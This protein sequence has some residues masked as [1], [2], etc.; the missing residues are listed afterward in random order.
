MS[1]NAYEWCEDYYDEH[2]YKYSP[3]T[4]P[5]GSEGG[6]ERVMRGGFFGETRQYAANR[7]SQQKAL[8]F[9]TLPPK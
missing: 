6:Q 3:S 1:G 8:F 7:C 9:R 5:K 4:N 2:Y